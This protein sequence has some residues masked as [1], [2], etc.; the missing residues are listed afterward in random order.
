MKSKTIIKK[1][2]LKLIIL[3]CVALIF[4]I[5]GIKRLYVAYNA[6]IFDAIERRDWKVYES[7]TDLDGP[8]FLAS[9]VYWILTG[10]IIGVIAV[11]LINW[12]NKFGIINSIAVL[13]LTL[14]I[15]MTGF[16]SD[17]IVNR[18]FNYFCGIFADNTL[19]TFLI[20][21]SLLILVG[22]LILW[23]TISV[24]KTR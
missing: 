4:I 14:G 1:F 18:Y 7:L 13:I 8:L 11:G 15:S 21:S 23:K 3:E 22:I 12:K 6:E 17:G 24:Y 2:N 5:S 20:G 16:F 19:I 9:H 10:M